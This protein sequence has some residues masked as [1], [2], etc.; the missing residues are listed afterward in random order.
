[1]TKLSGSKRSGMETIPAKFGHPE[2]VAMETITD[3]LFFFNGQY[4][5]RGL[6]YCLEILV[7]C[8]PGA[9]V[10]FMFRTY[11]PQTYRFSVIMKQ[12]FRQGH[13]DARA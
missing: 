7:M 12:S 4:L 3:S 8:A 1:M 10:Q 9:K 11:F 13:V 5:S 6:I 2:I